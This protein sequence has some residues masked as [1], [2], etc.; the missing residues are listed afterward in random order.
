MKTAATYNP[1][2]NSHEEN[3]LHCDV[4]RLLSKN[5][6]RKILGIRYETVTQLIKKGEIETVQI[7]GRKKIPLIML[8]KFVIKNSIAINQKREAVQDFES[9]E[10]NYKLQKIINKHREEVK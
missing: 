9:S 4:L 7:N 1:D 5:E 6:V 3:Q 8:R 10:L 2:L